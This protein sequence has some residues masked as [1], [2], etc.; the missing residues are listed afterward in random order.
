MTRSVLRLIAG[1]VSA[2]TF[3]AFPQSIDVE[4]LDKLIAR[5]VQEKK[6]VGLSA[7]IMHEGK[8]VLAKGYGIASLETRQ[9]VTAETMFGIGSIT[10]QFAC[11]L[12]LQLADEG[13]LAMERPCFQVFS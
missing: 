4:A 5:T 3:A 11:V 7:G 13:K 10:K 12:A 6:L 2:V 1:F 8:V 9:P